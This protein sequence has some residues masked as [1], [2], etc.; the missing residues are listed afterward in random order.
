MY[1][2]EVFCY[3]H[4]VP[5]DSEMLFHGRTFTGKRLISSPARNDTVWP[6][7]SHVINVL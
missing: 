1:L 5:G 4:Q 3:T 7:F 6:Q 2:R